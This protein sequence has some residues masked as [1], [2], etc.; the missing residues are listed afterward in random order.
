LIIINATLLRVDSPGVPTGGGD[1]PYVT[2][3]AIS[4]E[5][6]LDQPTSSQKFTLGAVIADAEAVLYVGKDELAAAMP[7]VALA[8]Q[9]RVLMQLKDENAS[10]LYE[11]LYARDR[12]HDFQSHFECYLKVRS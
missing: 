3:P 2:G 5:C 7:G 12:V 10:T 6:C 4:V 8:R 11:V 9:M 1:V